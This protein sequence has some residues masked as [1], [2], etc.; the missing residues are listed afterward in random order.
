[1]MSVNS[2]IVEFVVRILLIFYG[3]SDLIG[4]VWHL[5]S[6][7]TSDLIQGVAISFSGLFIG[8]SP[9]FFFRTNRQRFLY[10]LICILGIAFSLFMGFQYALSEYRSWNDVGEQ[11]LLIACFIFMAVMVKIK[12]A[13]LT[14]SPS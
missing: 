12:K 10:I 5:G 6:I 11:L 14:N 7:Y 4:V 1:M 3:L 2:R 8:F 13:N 9:L